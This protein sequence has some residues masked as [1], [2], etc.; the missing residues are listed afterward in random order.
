MKSLKIPQHPLLTIIAGAFLIVLF[1]SAYML[2]EPYLLK[3][4]T[5]V[6][7]DSDLPAEFDGVTIA[8][9]SDIHHGPF[10]SR[11]RV[12]RTVEMVNGLGSDIIVLGGDYVHRSPE[13]IEPVFSELSN[14]KAPLSV[15]A[16]LGNHDHWEDAELTRIAMKNAG[17]SSIDNNTYWISKGGANIRIGGVGDLWEDMQDIEKTTRGTS[18]KDFVVLAAI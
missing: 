1:V 12:K 14:L 3:V 10:F 11:A 9:L 16:V 18:K 13:Y 5:T 8:F 7:I 2:T 17:I 15:Y 6:I 4:T